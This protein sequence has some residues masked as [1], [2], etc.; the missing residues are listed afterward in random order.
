[1][2]LDPCTCAPRRL[3]R[4]LDNILRFVT[5]VTYRDFRDYVTRAYPV[6][7]NCTRSFSDRGG[8]FLGFFSE[9]LFRQYIIRSGCPITT[10]RIWRIWGRVSRTTR[11]D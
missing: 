3:Q 8:V 5:S 10:Q 9:I 6:H 4:R 7:T 1:M 11:R 2:L